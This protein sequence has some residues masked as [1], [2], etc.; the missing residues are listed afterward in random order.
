MSISC[1]SGIKRMDVRVCD[2][3]DTLVIK[4]IDCIVNQNATLE[5]N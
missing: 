1:I 5:L 4:V 3:I 2:E